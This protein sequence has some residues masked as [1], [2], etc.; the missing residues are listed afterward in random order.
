MGQHKD[1]CVIAAML[2]KTVVNVMTTITDIVAL[3]LAKLLKV[4]M[5]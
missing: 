2:G 1:V 4:T 5:Y 3:T